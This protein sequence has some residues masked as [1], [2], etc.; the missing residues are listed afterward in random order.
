MN[1]IFVGNIKVREMTGKNGPWETTRI[2]FKLDDL[3]LMGQHV[4]S[5]GFINLNLNRSKKGS[6]YL[7]IDQ[8]QPNQ[9]QAPKVQQVVDMGSG[10]DVTAKTTII[11]K[12]VIDTTFFE[13]TDAQF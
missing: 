2:S 1:K 7:E 9:E 8:W 11:K 4:N 12:E 5:A 6:E 10:S 3:N 13:D